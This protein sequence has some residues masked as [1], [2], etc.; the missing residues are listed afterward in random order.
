MMRR[1]LAALVLALTLAACETSNLDSAAAVSVSGRLLRADGNPAGGVTVG[2]ERDRSLGDLV[3]GTVL[4]PLTLFTACLADPPPEVCRGRS[5]RRTTTAADGSYSFQLTGKD[6]Q[7][8]FGNALTMTVSAE[9]PPAAGEV[10]GPS[11]AADFKVQATNLRLPDLVAWQPRV[12]VAPGRVAWEPLAGGSGSYQVG[13]EDAGGNAVWGFPATRPEV[14]FDARI[15]EDTTGSIAVSARSSATA[16]GTTVG[17]V[18]RSGRVGYRST[19][20]AP[21]S[22]GRP[23]TQSAG[24][25]PARCTLTDGDFANRLPAPATSTTVPPAQAGATIPS[26][27]PAMATIDLGQ[28]RNV[29]LV[30]VRG[31]SCAV[32]GSTDGQAWTPMGRSTGDTAVVPARTGAARYVRLTGPLTDLRE[33]SVW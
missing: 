11:V 31:C 10:A 20:G 29:S 21:V 14:S 28:P 19:A 32:E 22:R 30:V 2:F 12:T 4:V 1:L 13:V 27:P 16:E 8:F 33:V 18:R 7:S 17:V 23:C 5:V 9:L 26:P 25:S 24:P 15:L 3:A 6:T